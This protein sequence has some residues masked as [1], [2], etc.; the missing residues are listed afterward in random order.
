MNAYVGMYGLITMK[1][2]NTFRG[3]DAYVATSA[4]I[5]SRDAGVA[6]TTWLSF[7]GMMKVSL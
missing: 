4:N 1:G 3:S 2:V 7:F 5:F 6:P